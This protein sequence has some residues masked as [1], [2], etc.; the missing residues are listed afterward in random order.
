M[1]VIKLSDGSERL[2]VSVDDI[3]STFKVH[4]KRNG[5]T[6]FMKV[7]AMPEQWRCCGLIYK[8]YDIEVRSSGRPELGGGSVWLRGSTSSEDNEWAQFT[9]GSVLA[10]KNNYNH[11]KETF[12]Y[13]KQE[14]RR[15]I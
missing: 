2:N 11:L 4:L 7:L 9:F 6:I 8:R 10:A 12:F 5:N 15:S 14:F 13:M 3:D 1:T